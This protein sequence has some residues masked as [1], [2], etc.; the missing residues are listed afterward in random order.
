[1]RPSSFH[2]ADLFA[3]HVQLSRDAQRF[4]SSSKGR[5]DLVELASKLG[6]I[7]YQ[8]SIGTAMR[9]AS[10]A[11]CFQKLQHEFLIVMAEGQE[12]LLDCQ[13][14]D[15]FRIGYCTQE[16][17]QVLDCLPEI[18]V[19]AAT[20]LA[21]LVGLLC[22]EMALAFEQL[23]TTCPPW[24]QPKSV[25]GMWLPAKALYRHTSKDITKHVNSSHSSSCSLEGLDRLANVGISPRGRIASSCFAEHLS[26][27]S[28][29][30][31]TAS[32][33]ARSLLS[34]ASVRSRCSEDGQDQ[35]LWQQPRTCTVRMIGKPWKQRRSV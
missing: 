2:C 8:V 19:G 33:T 35:D 34:S 27:N 1:M 16:Y 29:P 25:L 5:S 32:V 6:N 17:Q 12:V 4:T 7:G 24:R 11:D 26:S 9:V 21:A 3:C 15:Q 23:G 22:S 18:F 14:R 13:F 20:R 31:P 28:K 10:D 30:Q